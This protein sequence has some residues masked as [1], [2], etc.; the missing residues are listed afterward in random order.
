MPACVRPKICRA[1]NARAAS[2]RVERGTP[3]AIGIGNYG[4]VHGQ[5][6]GSAA[7]DRRTGFNLHQAAAPDAGQ[8][9]AEI[10]AAETIGVRQ[11]IAADRDGGIVACERPATRGQEYGAAG[12]VVAGG[13]GGACGPRPPFGAQDQVDADLKQRI[14]QGQN[15]D[16]AAGARADCAAAQIARPFAIGRHQSIAQNTNGAARLGDE[17]R[18]AA[19]HRLTV[20]QPDPVGRHG[21][22]ARRGDGSGAESNHVGETVAMESRIACKIERAAADIHIG[23]ERGSSVDRGRDRAGRDIDIGRLCGICRRNVDR[24]ARYVEARRQDDGVA[25]NVSRSCN[26]ETQRA[27]RADRERDGIVLGHCDHVD[28][29]VVARPAARRACSAAIMR[30]RGVPGRNV[31]IGACRHLDIEQAVAEGQRGCLCRHIGSAAVDID[32][33]ILP[34]DRRHHRDIA[35]LRRQ[36]YLGT[37]ID[38]YIAGRRCRRA[39]GEAA[40]CIDEIACAVAHRVETGQQQSADIDHPGRSDDDAAGAVEPD[41]AALDQASAG[42]Q[43]ADDRAVHRDRATG[44]GG[45]DA[46][47][48][49]EIV[50]RCGVVA[51]EGGPA[52]GQEVDD[53]AA[54]RGVVGGP[55]D[56]RLVG[57]DADIVGARCPVDA[58]AARYDGRCAFECLGMHSACAADRE[59]CR[60]RERRCRL[61]QQDAAGG[62]GAVMGH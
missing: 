10:A 43:L 23:A 44:I 52:V 8:A 7:C 49:G 28:A 40:A 18:R 33:P 41:I 56:H 29:M 58:D 51:E 12:P 11:Q 50:L 60:Q 32:A 35:V 53:A 1:A 38:L 15:I 59:A 61:G 48:N 26:V 34:D 25:L 47:E 46:V 17:A 42:L 5:D 37:G 3:E 9:C 54:D 4:P 39:E 36:L 16:G 13:A 2:S 20:D 24:I 6:V 57:I 55:V 45:D 27:S 21:Q 19:C 14:V 30:D 22:V 62:Q 31:A